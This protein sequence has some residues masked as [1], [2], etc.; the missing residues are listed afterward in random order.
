MSLSNVKSKW[1]PEIRHYCPNTPIILV[2]T[3][4][5]L[6]GDDR[7]M[8]TASEVCIFSLKI[9]VVSLEHFSYVK[10]FK[11]LRVTKNSIICLGKKYGR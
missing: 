6:R 5:D 8:I 2:A 3:K 9:Y 4:I 1:A 10:I 11:L 7:K